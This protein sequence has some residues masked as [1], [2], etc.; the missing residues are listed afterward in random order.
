MYDDDVNPYD[1]A[2]E[3][4]VFRWRDA[5]RLD[6]V[7]RVQITD[8]SYDRDGHRP[9]DFLER[10]LKLIET[11]PHPLKRLT[12]HNWYGD[13][14]ESRSERLRCLRASRTAARAT[15]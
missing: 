12:L 5:R 14:T 4:V 7:T 11:D 10:K 9:Q 3:A 8:A 13:L 6:R 2:A 15:L 1:K